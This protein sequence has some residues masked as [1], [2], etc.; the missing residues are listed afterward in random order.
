MPPGPPL[1]NTPTLSSSMRTVPHSSSLSVVS[2]QRVLLKAFGAE[3][4]LTDPG[5]GM[6]GA[7]DKAKEIVNLLQDKCYMPQQVW[8]ILLRTILYWTE[9]SVSIFVYMNSKIENVELE[10]YCCLKTI[11][12][13][14]VISC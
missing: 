14:I 10:N 8:A 13:L 7:I 11:P 2:V 6:P 5:K 3:L 4:V 9:T 12:Q 1:N